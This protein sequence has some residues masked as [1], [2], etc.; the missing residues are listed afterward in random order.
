MQ[1]KVFLDLDWQEDVLDIR[2]QYPLD[3]RLTRLVA[4]E[5][6]T[7]HPQ[8]KKSKAHT[9]LTTDFLVTVRSDDGP[10]LVAVRITTTRRLQAAAHLTRLEL[11][12]RVWAHK[13]VGFQLRTERETCDIRALNLMF[14]H[15]FHD[16]DRR[17]TGGKSWPMCAS[18]FIG[19]LEVESPETLL[20]DFVRKVE[21]AGELQAGE[22][23]SALRYVASHRLVHFDLTV[24]VHSGL[25]LGAFLRPLGKESAS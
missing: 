21:R 24:S 2:E 20:C 12:R 8:D 1:R 19:M 7:K 3:R 22:G 11:E 25:P 23:I 17:P 6:G 5:L 16:A 18:L 4:F 14:L 13:G 9:V 15:E 10:T